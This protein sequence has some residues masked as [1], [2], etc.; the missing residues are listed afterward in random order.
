MNA[1]EGVFAHLDLR[2]KKPRTSGITMVIDK[3][4]GLAATCDLL[5]LAGD[6]I[7]HWKLSFGTS[8]LMS[9]TLLRDKIALLR[10]RDICV[11]PGGTLA[12]YAVV[13][14]RYRE[15]VQRAR[16][17]GFNGLE[18]SDGT[19]SFSPSTRRDAIRYA[20][21]MEFEVVSEVGK[22]HPA[23]QPGA[24]ALAELALADI[25]S[26][27]RWVVVEGRESG[28]GVGVYDADGRVHEQ[29]VDTIVSALDGHLQALIWEAP[30][31]CHQAYFILRLG[32]DVS[33]GNIQPGEV[34]ATEA[35]RVGLRFETLGAVVTDREPNALSVAG[36]R[37]RL[38]YLNL[39]GS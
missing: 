22:K 39:A 36:C 35:L 4:Q 14:G 38:D 13:T 32:G 34:L 20:L 21:D 11:Y 10:A 16:A 26:G 33:L 5:E 7:D 15:F 37:S 3:G 27:A 1:W 25:D 17:L 29:D 12:E 19:I 31:K 6:Y 28:K 2:P 24:R 30:L 23:D 9:E 8:A 18:I